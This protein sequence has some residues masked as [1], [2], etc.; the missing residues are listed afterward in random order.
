[1]RQD[2]INLSQY[3]SGN[4]T[5]SAIHFK[6]DTAEWHQ[7]V[8]DCWQPGPRGSKK[9]ISDIFRYNQFQGKRCFVIGGGA[10]LRGFD[11]S[12]LKDE[13]T[14]GINK[15]N[16]VFH[17]WV[18]FSWDRVIYNWYQTQ[19]IKSIVVMV[20][21]SNSIM[22]RVFFVRSA[23]SFGIPTEID[24]IFI[25]THT[26]YASINFAIALGFSPIY[27]L[28]FDY[29]PTEGKYHVTDDWGHRR[30]IN[31]T[32]VRFKKEINEYS[33]YVINIINLNPES[34]LKTFPTMEIREVI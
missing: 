24:R 15:I 3:C 18:L 9:P 32:F 28:G 21:V 5:S 27:L 23:G 25:G 11:F 31:N 26:G 8:N 29:K 10:S 17:P 34:E 33:K 30:D 14:I 7:Y 19:L 2:K 13:Y 6:A 4:I 12:Q 22:D 20:D 1:M 16:Q